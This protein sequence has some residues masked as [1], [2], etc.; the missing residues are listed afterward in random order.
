[1]CN[2]RCQK[3]H[4]KAM[5]THVAWAAV[6]LGAHLG[7]AVPARGHIHGEQL[8][9]VHVGLL[10]ARAREA[11]VADLEPTILVDQDVAGLEVPVHD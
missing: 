9:R 1:M 6:G 11:K 4:G 2:W 10:G 7:G 3:K 8:M 5:R